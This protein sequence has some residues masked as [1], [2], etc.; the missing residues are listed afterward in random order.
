[1]Q[2]HTIAPSASRN[3]AKLLLELN[4]PVSVSLGN[5]T[6]EIELVGANSYTMEIILNIN[7]LFEVMNEGETTIMSGL[8]VFVTNIFIST[9][10]ENYAGARLRVT[11]PGTNF[12]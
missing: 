12:A 1:M 10:G 6:Y 9:I 3:E 5:E 4:A 8:S 7:G 11:I 2:Q